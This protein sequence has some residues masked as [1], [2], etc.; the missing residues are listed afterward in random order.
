MSAGDGPRPE[1]STDDE[2]EGLFYRFL[3]DETGPLMFAREMLTSIAT[4]AAVGVLLFAISGVW[5]PMVA[6]ESSSMD[7]NMQKGDLIF[8]TEPGRFAPDAARGDTGV[9]TYETGQEVGYKTFNDY[10]T[11]VIYES[12]SEFRPPIIHRARFWVDEGENWYDR[13][14]EAWVQGADNCDQMDNCPAPHAGFITKGDN[15]NYYDQTGDIRAP[16]KPEWVIGTARVR[17]PYL[18]WVRLGVSGAMVADTG[19]T[20]ATTADDAATP[21]PVEMVTDP[22]GNVS[23]SS[24]GDVTVSGGAVA[25]MASPSVSAQGPTPASTAPTATA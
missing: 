16:V 3:N 25:S 8:V 10:G 7:P 20:S 17:I 14:N 5:P 22:T 23:T 9:V 18:G 12:S 4:V 2:D 6:V 1:P 11:V 15:N 24:T 13:A 21:G 19:I